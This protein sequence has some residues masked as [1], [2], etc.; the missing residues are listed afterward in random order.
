MLKANLGKKLKTTVDE[1]AIYLSINPILL[2]IYPIYLSIYLFLQV[3]K[4]NL[5]KKLKTTVD[6]NGKFSYISADMRPVPPGMYGLSGSVVIELLRF[7]IHT[8]LSKESPCK[9]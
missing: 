8:Y 9:V 5:G 2:S 3:L 1:N 7:L 6:E 4:A